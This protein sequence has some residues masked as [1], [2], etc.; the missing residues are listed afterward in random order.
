MEIETSLRVHR[1][2]MAGARQKGK[3]NKIHRRIRF[4]CRCRCPVHRLHT[5]CHH[6]RPP[7]SGDV[8]IPPGTGQPKPVSNSPK[9]HHPPAL[10]RLPIAG[11][12]RCI[13]GNRR[14]CHSAPPG[15]GIYGSSCNP[16]NA[17]KPSA[18]VS[19]ALAWSIAL[20]LRFRIRHDLVE[21]I[22]SGSR[23]IH[24]I[25]HPRHASPKL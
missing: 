11:Y 10:A 17:C 19:C 5:R 15:Q 1:G 25:D 18:V 2:F 6:L 22:R 3:E 14:G 4:R 21:F 16:E 13:S 7:L 8:S 23:G 24:D 9:V 12:S 20:L